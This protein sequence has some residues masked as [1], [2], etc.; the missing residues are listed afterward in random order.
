MEIIL[1]RHGESE[2]NRINYPEYK[3]FTGQWECHVTSEGLKKAE[4]LKSL[5]ELKDVEIC[6]ASDLIRTKE[7]AQAIF[8]SKII[9]L[10]KRLRERSLGVFEGGGVDDIRG[11]IQYKKYFENHEYMN[12]RHDFIQK[13]PGGESYTDVCNRV[14]KFLSE[15]LAMNYKKVAIVSHMCTIRCILKILKFL[16]EEETLALKKINVSQ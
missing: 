3:M 5:D 10:D 8:P 2:A 15:L 13:A 4:V 6:F 14:N 9:Q 1:I 12:F 7:T 16:T 11:C